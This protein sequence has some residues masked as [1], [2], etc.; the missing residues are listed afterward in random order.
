MSFVS[1][2]LVIVL[3]IMNVYRSLLNFSKAFSMSIVPEKRWYDVPVHTFSGGPSGFDEALSGLP[4]FN[5][6]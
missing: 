5:T 6:A 1:R 3:W 4:A 2:T